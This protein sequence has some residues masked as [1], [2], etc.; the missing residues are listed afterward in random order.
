VL[1][2]ETEP[3]GH[4]VG[5]RAADR[6]AVF[7]HGHIRAGRTEEAKHRLLLGLRDEVVAVAAVPVEAVWVY[8]SELAPADMVEFGRVLPD[9]GHEPGWIAGLPAP[10][11]DR[12]AEPDG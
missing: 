7:V 1:F 10:L 5:G 6:D 9:P 2:R 3:A 8:L 12:F 11:R 4:F